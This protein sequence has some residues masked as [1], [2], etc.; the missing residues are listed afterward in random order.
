MPGQALH[1][2]LAP[3]RQFVLGRT[4]TD[5]R[6]CGVLRGCSDAVDGAGFM[7][8]GGT[9]LLYELGQ[10]TVFLDGLLV[11]RSPLDGCPPTLNPRVRGSSP[12]RRTIDQ[13][14]DLVLCVGSEP[15]SC[16]L[17]TVVCSSCAPEPADDSDHRRTGRTRRYQMPP[18][19]PR[20][21][22]PRPGCARSPGS[23]RIARPLAGLG[24]ALTAGWRRAARP[25]ADRPPQGG[26]G[27]G[28]RAGQR[29]R[30]HRLRR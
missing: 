25:A 8:S 6:P 9:R 12:W 30:R 27:G 5:R 10:T 22:P 19:T 26:A 4:A 18:G 3:R 7:G 11:V 15:F 1:R 14:S 2:L 16:L 28:A 17:W 21:P 23:G 20:R 13:G 24:R 29:A